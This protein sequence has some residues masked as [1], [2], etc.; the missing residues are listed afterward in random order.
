MPGPIR[1]GL[2]G[3]LLSLLSLPALAQVYT[4]VD[5]NGVKQFSDKPPVEQANE[6]RTIEVP[7]IDTVSVRQLP[8]DAIPRSRP[9]A[10][11]ARRVVMYSAAWCGVCTRAKAYF[12]SNNIAFEERDIETSESARKQFERLG[13]RGVPLI[14]VGQQK[15]SGFSANSFEQLYRN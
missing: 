1:K 2:A 8:R 15:L 12:R 11:S 14:L 5:A 4:W 7:Q 10:A 3:L 9:Q 13:G 6:L